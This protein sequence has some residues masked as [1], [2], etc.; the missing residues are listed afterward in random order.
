VEVVVALGLLQLLL[1]LHNNS[2]SR[3]LLVAT[4]WNL[5]RWPSDSR[6]SKRRF[7]KE[8]EWEW[9]KLQTMTYEE[10]NGT[11]TFNEKIMV[12]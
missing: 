10:Y 7:E 8:N 11:E 4:T 2:S 12:L 5:M 3:S 9:L 1:L 6:S